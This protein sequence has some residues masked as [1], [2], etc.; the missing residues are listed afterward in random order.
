MKWEIKTL[1][2]YRWRHVFAEHTHHLTFGSTHQ[3]SCSV[4]FFFFLFP[5]VPIVGMRE[6]I[7]TPN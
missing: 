4:F 3:R 7:L 6:S 2:C 5:L 1:L